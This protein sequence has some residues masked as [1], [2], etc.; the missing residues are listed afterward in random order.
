MAK[1]E[2]PEYG[3]GSCFRNKR[4]LSNIILQKEEATKSE[5][6]N[7]YAPQLTGSMEVTKAMAKM[8]LDKFKKGE[9]H[10]SERDRTKGEPVVKMDVGANVSVSD[11][12]QKDGHPTGA[13]VYFWFRDEYQPKKKEVSP[14]QN[15]LDEEIP[16]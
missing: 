1:Y 12:I 7:Q 4:R 11:N 9:T 2:G 14:P 6:Y 16:F 5:F 8:L 10:P 3:G 13:F 15:A